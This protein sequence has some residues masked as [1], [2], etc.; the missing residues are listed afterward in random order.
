MGELDLVEFELAELVAHGRVRPRQEAS[1]DAIGDLAQPE[2]EARRLN[3]VRRDLRRRPDLA[4]GDQGFQRLGG[5]DAG[6]GKGS[7]HRRTR[8]RQ[9]PL[10]KAVKQSLALTCL[11][12]GS[13]SLAFAGAS[14]ILTLPF[15]PGFTR[16]GPA[17]KA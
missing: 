4:T 1:A 8:L 5:Q 16:G 7:F 14:V 3:L 11:L 17:E 9:R 13:S 2:I 15:S 6:A 12:H 10:G